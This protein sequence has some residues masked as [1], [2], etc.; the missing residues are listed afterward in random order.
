MCGKLILIFSLANRFPDNMVMSNDELV[1]IC[2][3]D[4][5]NFH[6]QTIMLLLAVVSERHMMFKILGT[7]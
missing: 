4:A 7:N 5:N 3:G 1:M 6:K 2:V